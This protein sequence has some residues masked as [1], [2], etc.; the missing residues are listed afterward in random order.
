M[1][2]IIDQYGDVIIYSEE[3]HPTPFYEFNG[4]IAANPYGVLQVLLDDDDL[5]EVMYNGGKQC[6]KIAHRKH[7]MCRTNIWVEDEEGI[8]ISKN[9]ASFTDVPLGDGPGMV[10]IFD[11]RLPDG[12]RVNGTI[13]PVSPDGPT[14]TI[15]KFREDPITIVDLIRWGTVSPRLAAMFWTWVDGMGAKPANFVI[16]GGTGSGKTTTL[17]CLGMFVPWSDRV[18]SVEDTAEL[19]IHHDHWLRMETRAH[20]PDGTSEIDMNDC[21][22]SSLRMRPDR[23]IVGEV[24]GPEA[25]TLLMAMN[26]GHDGSFGSLHA[27]TANETVKRL[28][29][30]PM[31]VPAIMLSALDLIIMQARLNVGG[32]NIRRITEVAEIAG[33]EGDTPRLNP[34]WKYD[35]GQGKIV[36]TGVPSKVREIICAAKG[37]TPADFEA[38]VRQK[39]QILTDLVNREIRDIESVTRVIQT[40]HATVN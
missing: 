38:I 3:G 16:A 37:C 30:P 9:I 29:N 22:K 20:R 34:I 15:R 40:Y 24:R 33:M 27:N 35:A 18:L 8:Q 5:E 32:K 4:Q 6:V 12:S 17:N 11:G 7:G 21:L 39:E 14:L 2:D 28:V 1:A 36:E 10:P 25:A 26:T 31:A 19:S 13:P 23:V